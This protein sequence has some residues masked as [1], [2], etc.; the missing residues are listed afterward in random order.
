MVSGLSHTY[1]NKG[2]TGV[3]VQVCTI[4][5]DY[6][7]IFS[8]IGSGI[9]PRFNDLFSNISPISQ[10]EALFVEE[11]GSTRRKPRYQVIIRNQSSCVTECLICRYP[12]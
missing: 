9:S 4:L 10:L 2:M 11:T 1:T 6:Y 7:M 3:Y 12:I 5:K 8:I